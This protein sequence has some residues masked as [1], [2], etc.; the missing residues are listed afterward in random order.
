MLAACKCSVCLF[1]TSHKLSHKTTPTRQAVVTCCGAVG[2]GCLRL[3][4]GSAV[5]C[6]TL[7]VSA[8]H[9]R[10]ASW[11]TAHKCPAGQKRTCYY[12]NCV[13]SSVPQCMRAC[14]RESECASGSFT[15]A[16]CQKLMCTPARPRLS[17]IVAGVVV[18]PGPRGNE[19]RELASFS[20]V[21]SLNPAAV[22]G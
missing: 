21:S 18:A 17:A 11:A 22:T 15:V 19:I 10:K 7:V 6:A 13:L 14:R 8:A 16:A 4:Q 5:Q 3:P 2:T 9:M 1:I 20:R 12:I